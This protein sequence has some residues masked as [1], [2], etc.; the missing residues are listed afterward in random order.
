MTFTSPIE[1]INSDLQNDRKDNQSPGYNHPR[2]Y[3]GIQGLNSLLIVVPSTSPFSEASL[4]P[5]QQRISA[6]SKVVAKDARAVQK[7]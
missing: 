1:V 2:D 4:S 3:G 5:I 6:L 7:L